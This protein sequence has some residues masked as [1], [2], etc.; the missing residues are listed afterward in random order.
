MANAIIKENFT[1]FTR[2]IVSGAFFIGSL[3][4]HN[5]SLCKGTKVKQVLSGSY[6]PPPDVVPHAADFLCALA[7]DKV[8]DKLRTAPTHI[9]ASENS[10]AWK[11]QRAGTASEPT[12]LSFSHYIA[13][14]YSPEASEVDAATRSVPYEMGWSSEDW[15]VISDFQ[16]LKNLGVYEV[17]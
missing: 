6:F 11:K 14:A 15:E 12:N 10:A 4:K 9:T 7:I 8:P 2:C 1:R 13:A 17:E 3:L 5:G 16:L